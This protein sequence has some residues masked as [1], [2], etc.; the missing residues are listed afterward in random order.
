M[1]CNTDAKVAFMTTREQC[2]LVF[3]VHLETNQSLLKGILIKRF[4]SA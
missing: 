1:G 3:H 2:S 4:P